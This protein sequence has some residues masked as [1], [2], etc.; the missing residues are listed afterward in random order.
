[1]KPPILFVLFLGREDSPGG[2]AR[3]R[4]RT[5]VLA[6]GRVHKKR[7]GRIPPA[8]SRAERLRADDLIALY[9]AFPEQYD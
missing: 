2:C 6:R 4:P 5:S 9:E 8:E 7:F 3:G 1:M